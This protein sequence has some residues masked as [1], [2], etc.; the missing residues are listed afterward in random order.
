MPAKTPVY[1]ASLLT[2]V[3]ELQ[4]L[5]IIVNAD[6]AD[7]LAAR[8]G[9]ASGIAQQQLRINNER[10]LKVA[11][12]VVEKQDEV[13]A[14]AVRALCRTL[15]VP[16]PA[17]YA[18]KSNGLDAQEGAPDADPTGAVHAPADS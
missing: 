7:V 8:L 3:G 17:E 6:S 15:D 1:S 11:E 5:S 10:V 9:Q 14:R 18:T 16:I 12:T 4:Q 2:T 13:L